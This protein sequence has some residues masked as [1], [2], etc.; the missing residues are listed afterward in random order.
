MQMLVYEN[1]NK[2]ISAT[3][4][5]KRMKNNVDAMDTD[6]EAVRYATGHAMHFCYLRI[7]L[8][9]IFQSYNQVIGKW[10]IIKIKT[11]LIRFIYIDSLNHCMDYDFYH[12]LKFLLE[13]DFSQNSVFVIL[14]CVFWII[15]II[16]TIQGED[17]SYF[18]DC[19]YYRWHYG[20][21]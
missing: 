7:S 13:L 6:M 17:G 10:L 5:I 3:E 1:Y 21:E 12:D 19:S 16:I 2:F 8:S 14:I 4:T 11:Y 18:Q 9:C 20:R 15:I